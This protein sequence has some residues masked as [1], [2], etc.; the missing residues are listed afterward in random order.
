MWT[1]TLST[2]ISTSSSP[3]MAGLSHAGRGGRPPGRRAPGR[4]GGGRPS[5]P[6]TKPPMWA[7]IA[8]PPECLDQPERGEPVDDLEDEPEA[9]HEDRRDVDELVEEAEEDQRRDARPRVEHHVGAERRRDRARTPRSSGSSRSGPSRPGRAPR[10]RR[11]RGRTAGTGPRPMR[12]STLFAE[13]P[14]VEHVAQEVQPAA[15]QELA[16]DER[17]G[18]LRDEVAGAHAAVRSAG[19][20]P[21]VVTNAFERAS[22]PLASSPSSQAKP[23]K[24]AT[25]MPIV[26]TG[27]RRVGLASRSGITRRGRSG[28]LGR[29]RGAWSGCGASADGRGRRS[30]P[31]AASGTALEDGLVD[32]VPRQPHQR[33]RPSVDARDDVHA[34]QVVPVRAAAGQPVLGLVVAVGL[35]DGDDPRCSPCRRRRSTPVR[36]SRP[37][38]TSE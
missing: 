29:L 33:R 10:R 6:A 15:V 14:Q 19:T 7:K 34:A 8:T 11:R 23:T 25:T 35:V 16:R 12:S 30:A 13:D 28:L 36:R 17:R 27:V 5:A 20:T 22:P 2:T 9:E 4:P 21:H 1:R 38:A 37:P 18:L 31:A 26:T 24:Q 3:A 32:A